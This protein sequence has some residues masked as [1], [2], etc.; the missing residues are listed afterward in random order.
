[1]H[2]I[3]IIIFF[4]TLIFSCTFN[5]LP[6]DKKLTSYVNTF[7]GTGGNGHT[8]PGATLP[9]GMMQL[10][11]DTRLDG[12]DGASGYH[13]KDNHIYGFS[14]THL[15]GTGITD[16]MD[17]LLMPTNE[18]IFNNGS[19]G[20]KGYRSAFSH[21]NEVATPGYYSVRLDDTKIE[22]SLTVS[23]RSGMH[24][25]LFP[26]NSNQIVIL[27]LE[28][29]DRVLDAA[30]FS[31]DNRIVSGY[32]FSNAWAK[33]QRLFFD[34]EFSRPYTNVTF[35][36]EQ[37]TGSNVKAAF[38]FDSSISNSLE[39]K[40]GI[41]PVDK[42]GAK[43]NR[44]TELRD[45]SFDQLREEADDVWEK[46]LNKIVVETYEEEDMYNFYSALYHTMI[47][48][49]LYQDVDGRYRGMDMEI[50]QDKS[51]NYYTVFSLWD[52]FR[53]AHP[54]YTIIEQ[55]RTNDFI[56]TFL[57]KYDEGG[58]I[59]IWDL[60]ANYTNTMIGYHAIPVMADAY[61][62][63]IRGYDID[64]AFEA[65]K[66]SAMQNKNGLE[67]YKSTGFVSVE[68]EPESVSKTLEYAYDDWTIAAMA[69]ALA[70]EEDYKTFIQRA[71]YYKNVYDPETKFMRGR[72]NNKWFAPFDPYEVNFNYTEANSWHYSFYVPQ[73][74]SGHIQLIGGKAQYEQM[75]DNLFNA[76]TE[77]SGRD[78]A[79]ITGLI[80]QYAQGN[81]PSHHMAYLYN[82]VNKPA[83]TQA[84]IRKI[85]EEQYANAPDGISGNEDCGQMSAWYIFSALGFYPVTPGTNE[86]IFGSPIV[87]SAIITLENGKTFQ[88]NAPNNKEGRPYIKS[89]LLNGK[90]HY[91]SY[92]N[93]NDII[94]GGTLTYEM[95]KR[96]SDWGASDDHIPVTKIEDHIITTPPFVEKGDVA[97]ENETMIALKSIQPEATIYYSLGEDFIKY[98]TP[99]TIT[100]DSKLSTYAVLNGK[101]S[102]TLKTSFK[103]INPDIKISL[104]T[105]YS[106]QYSAG[107]DRA[108]I[109][110]IL[111][112]Q[113]FRTGTW[114]GYVGTDVVAT[115]D[116]SKIQ[117][118]NKL[119]INFLSDQ[120]YWIFYPEKVSF[121]GSTDGENFDLIGSEKIEIKEIN[122]AKIKNIEINNVKAP[123][124]YIKIVAKKIGIVPEWHIGYKDD[125]LGWIF[126]DEIQINY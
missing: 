72:I 40:I 42:E 83:K 21:D 14:H 1:M 46:Q 51:L 103:K 4:C 78:Q 11:P 125:G 67:S 70:N 97:F 59:P 94:N 111:G 39:V 25:Y 24:S 26:E 43:L 54:L 20:E 35:L 12:W 18:V 36:N 45:K 99:I 110:G 64:K 62:K 98:E 75:L 28:H 76:N 47:A 84:M 114:Q 48:P 22:V 61:L 112:S 68:T 52:T 80:G 16:Y 65:M 55:E 104:A 89:V 63:G 96:H 116:I 5:N 69:K 23:E 17:V 82:F 77:T 34:L 122:T 8:Y 121:Y 56:K 113:D 105:T 58:I 102:A 60:S 29:R 41:S 44:V 71:Q 115:V 86:Y 37:T 13:Y 57:N 79:D 49:N 123:Y 101:K 30:L 19:D 74:I 33:D 100:D 66:H 91:K 6:S 27:D 7:V 93:H 73:D 38:E 106:N 85:L 10:S 53:A 124:R 118:I 88:I 31:N 81:E 2:R 92:L 117:Q 15:S 9:F 120:S 126:V 50:Y 119:T 109:D 90:E 3:S 32:R 108:L 107:G 95:S 87:K